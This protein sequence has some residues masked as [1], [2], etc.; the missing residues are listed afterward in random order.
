MKSYR[1][2]GAGNS[3]V[4]MDIRATIAERF[5]SAAMVRSLCSLNSTD[6]LILI[7]AAKDADFRMEFY[8]PDGT[9]GMMCGNGGRCAVAFADLLGIHPAAADGIYRFEA[10][11]GIHTGKILS[12]MG[13]TKSVVIS[14]GDVDGYERHPEGLFLNTGT[15][16]FVVWV[17]DAE[18]VDVAAEG[19]V[20]RHDARF[21][22]EGTNVNFVTR[23]ADGRLRVRTFEKGVEAETLSCG[24]G[25][26]AS[27]L[28][29]AIE[30]GVSGEGSY[31]VL[32]ST[33]DTLTIGFNRSGDRFTDV[34]LTGPTLCE[35]EL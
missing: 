11:D 18:A 14:M 2:S 5:R 15:R 16:H 24:T 1:Y 35:G 10:P 23:M 6:G 33:G 4:M 25:S 7:D 12:H 29:A 17:P 9:S 21:A 34:R 32:A 3:F 13:E 8:N 26:V 19:P 31:T 22:P 27:A 30:D 28:A 20:L